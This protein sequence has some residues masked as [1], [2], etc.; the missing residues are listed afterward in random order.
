MEASYPVLTADLVDL[1]AFAVVYLGSLLI[2]LQPLALA[3]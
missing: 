3:P 1:L 2:C